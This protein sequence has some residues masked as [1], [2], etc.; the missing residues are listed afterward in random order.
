[1]IPALVTRNGD[2]F[3]T[4]RVSETGRHC[5][6]INRWNNH[7]PQGHVQVLL[8]LLREYSVQAAL[9]APRFCISPGT[10]D[11][12]VEV[13]GAAGDMNGEV[14]FEEGI[15]AETVSKLRGEIK[16]ENRVYSPAQCPSSYSDWPWRAKFLGL[17]V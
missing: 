9:D 3:L 17:I 5:Q 1:M 4:Y 13:S 14:Y 11:A 16:R 10:P 7:Q 15:S 12:T 6:V 8:N 2:L